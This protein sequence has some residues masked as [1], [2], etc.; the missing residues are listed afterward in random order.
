MLDELWQAQSIWSRAAGRMKARIELTRWVALAIVVTVAILGAV[1]AA[2]Y[3]SAPTASKASAA[4][5]AFGA[6]IL[7]LLR[8]GWS[9]TSLKNWTRARS[10]SEALK[11]DVYLWLAVAGPFENDAAGHILRNRSDKLRRDVADLQSELSGVEAETRSLPAVR[12]PRSYFDVRWAAQYRGYYGKKVG[13]I[14]MSIRRYR[15]AE[16]VISVLGAAVGLTA[17]L[18]DWPLAAWIAVLATIGTALSVHVSAARYEF[19]RIEFSRTAEEL[20]RIGG[21]ATAPGVTDDELRALAV[22]AENV[23]SV[24]NKAWMA[25]LAEDPE[26][27][28]PPAVGD[29]KDA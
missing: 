29:G 16:I 12:D 10:V 23:I 11:S 9:G 27:H 2:C 15:W 19:Q 20:R 5:A 6:A 21:L 18:T 22:R 3:D 25:K 14:N 1:A 24:E 4:V 26:D 8:R 17:A 28:T 7:P 13:E